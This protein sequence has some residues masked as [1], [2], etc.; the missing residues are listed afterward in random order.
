MAGLKDV[1]SIGQGQKAEALEGYNSL[2]SS[3]LNK[4]ASDAQTKFNNKQAV[5]GLV[6]TVGGA[7]TAYGMNNSAAGA[8]VGKKISPTASVLQNKG[9]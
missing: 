5:L 1:V 6:G 8:A 4:A 3:S 2:A 7:A 9:Y